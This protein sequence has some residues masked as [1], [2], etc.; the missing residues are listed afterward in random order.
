MLLHEQEEDVVELLSEDSQAHGRYNHADNTIA[1]TWL[2]LFRKIKKLDPLAA[3]Y[4]SH[5]AF[6]GQRCIPELFLPR[7]A[8]RKNI[9][10]ALGLP[11]YYLFITIQPGDKPIILHHVVHLAVWHWL[12][13]EGIVAGSE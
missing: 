2:T 13:S 5:L 3:E 10:E 12:R 11:E 6:L 7:L 9:V 1:L 8:T 4:L